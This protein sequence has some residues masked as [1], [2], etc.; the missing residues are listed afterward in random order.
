MI[1]LKGVSRRYPARAEAPGGMI[2]A[3]DD[4]SLS[5]APGEW[6][7]IMGPSGSGKSTLVNLIGCLDRPSSGEIWLD[8]QDVAN[9]SGVELNRVRAEKIGFVFQQFQRQ[10]GHDGEVFDAQRRQHARMIGARILADDE[11]RIRQIEIA[12]PASPSDTLKKL[13]N[14][15]FAAGRFA[16][17]EAA[18]KDS[19]SIQHQPCVRNGSCGIGF[20]GQILVPRSGVVPD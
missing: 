20:P 16:S 19:L 2:Y 4:F 7:S 5:V 11:N 8:G 9:I 15:Y 14:T 3:L 12:Q 13:G 17:A 6:V 1:K 18:F 10:I